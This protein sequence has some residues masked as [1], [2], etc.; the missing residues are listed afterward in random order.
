M[1]SEFEKALKA[2]EY[3]SYEEKME[4]AK[5]LRENHENMAGHFAVCCVF[6]QAQG[7]EHEVCDICFKRFDTSYPNEGCEYQCQKRGCD[8]IAV[9]CE[10]CEYYH[11]DKKG[12]FCSEFYCHLCLSHMPKEIYCDDCEQ[13][14]YNKFAGSMTY[15]HPKFTYDEILQLGK[16]LKKDHKNHE[17]HIVNECI[18]CCG[19]KSGQLACCYCYDPLD[20]RLM[21]YSMEINIEEIF[22]CDECLNLTSC[23]SKC[24]E[25]FRCK[26]CEWGLTGHRCSACLIDMP[27]EIYC[28]KHDTTFS[29]PFSV[30]MTKAC[31]K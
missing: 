15:I 3:M 12:E 4:F 22:D 7:E 1:A 23:C 21:D 24:K 26:K 8:V 10:D 29:N 19:N 6:C 30:S 11:K 5:E 13:T 20:A 31:K 25:L 18:W 27:E 17:Y 28:E 9:V 16:A 2:I 14:Y